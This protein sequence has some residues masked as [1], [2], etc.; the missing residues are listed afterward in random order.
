MDAS[1]LS[2]MDSQIYA[3]AARNEYLMKV[4]DFLSTT[5]QDPALGKLPAELR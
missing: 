4:A 2:F 1:H 3:W 5:Q